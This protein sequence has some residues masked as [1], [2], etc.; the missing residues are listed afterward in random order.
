MFFL[1]VTRIGLLSIQ[2]DGGISLI[3]VFTTAQIMANY[4]EKGNKNNMQLFV[5]LGSVIAGC[6]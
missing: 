4:A 2:F 6:D 1:Q 3:T 5:T